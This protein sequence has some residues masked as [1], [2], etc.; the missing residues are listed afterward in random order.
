[1][2]SADA[3][4]RED[5]ERRL[6]SLPKASLKAK[7]VSRLVRMVVKRWP[8]GKPVA[9]VK[10]ARRVL[11]LASIFSRLHTS[12]TLISDVKENG[13]RGEWIVPRVCSS[14]EKAILY[15]HGG[16]YVSCSP[17][18]HRVI[19]CS[20]ARMAGV[21]VFALDYRLAPEHPFPVAIDD[22]QAAYQWLLE[23]G[24]KPHNLALAGDSA[25]GGLVIATLIR[26]REKQL[27]LPACGACFSPWVDL[28]GTCEY[29]NTES[30]AMFRSTDVGAFAVVYL[31][32]AARDLPEVSP[33]FADLSGLPH[34]SSRRAAQS[35]CLMSCAAAREGFSRRRHHHI[36]HLSR[37]STRMA[38]LYWPDPGIQRS[39]AGGRGVHPRP[40]F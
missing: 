11:G 7:M 31:G 6:Q 27:K 2:T 19:T 21:R 28:T 34:C 23:Q 17:T 14:P 10:H 1:M 24:I 35:C 20:L 30:C 12:E 26:L 13:V 37:C 39:P 4:A 40:P 15:L 5:V 9:M 29:R 22:A 8:R 33:I 18:T 25:G 36:E 16:G 3:S 32:S 38:S